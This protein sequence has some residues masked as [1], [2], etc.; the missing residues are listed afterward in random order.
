MGARSLT[1]KSTK[2]RQVGSNVPRRRLWIWI[3]GLLGLFWVLYRRASTP[4]KQRVAFVVLTD[5]RERHEENVIPM[6]AHVEQKYG[7]S[8]EV[9]TS[10][11]ISL[12]KAICRLD[13]TSLLYLYRPGAAF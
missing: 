1:S 7:A 11:G 10:S 9:H 12:K 5:P 6:L 8:S 4:V 3:F 13:W 2:D